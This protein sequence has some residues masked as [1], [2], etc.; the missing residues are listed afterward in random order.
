[1]TNNCKFISC[2]SLISDRNNKNNIR[3]KKAIG[4]SNPLALCDI[5]WLDVF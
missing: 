1:M 3:D 5:L 4:L 2:K